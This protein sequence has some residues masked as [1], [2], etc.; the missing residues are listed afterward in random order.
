MHLASLVEHHEVSVS[1]GLTEPTWDE[2]M[3]AQSACMDV[4]RAWGEYNGLEF[5][6]EPWLRT[7]ATDVPETNAAGE[8][9]AIGCAEEYTVG[10]SWDV[11]V[12]RGSSDTPGTTYQEI[13]S[14]MGW[15]WSDRWRFWR[16]WFQSMTLVSAAMDNVVQMRRRHAEVVREVEHNES[17]DGEDHPG[18]DCPRH[19]H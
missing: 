1:F 13:T 19:F 9:C 2:R 18:Q 14:R 5:T 17:C 16:G 7:R 12:G 15:V 3:W 10:V 4:V 8:V 11:V 6:I